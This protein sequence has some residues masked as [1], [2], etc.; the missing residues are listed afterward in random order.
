MAAFMPPPSG[1]KAGAIVW[2]YLRDSGGTSQELSVPQQQQE[3]ETFCAQYGFVRAR[4]FS[5]VARSGTSVVGRDA[6]LQMVES[7]MDPA[8]RPQAILV[9]NYSRIARDLTDA[10]Y[11]KGLIRRCGILIHSLTDPVTEGEYKPLVEMLID[12]SNQ[13]K[14]RQTSRDVKRALHSMVAQGFS[15]GGNPPRGYIEEK[16]QVGSKRDGTPRVVSRWVPDPELWE[17]GQQAW[18]MRAQ[19]RSYQE[20]QQATGG[21]IYGSKGSWNS[22]FANE[23]YLGIGKCGEERILDHHPA[24]V[25]RATWDRVQALRRGHPRGS[26]PTTT[27]FPRRVGAPSLLVGL[28]YCEHCG[29]ALSH[30]TYKPPTHSRWRC[31]ICGRKSRQGWKSCP[32]RMI[33]ARN[34]EIVVLHTVLDRILTAEAFNDLLSRMQEQFADNKVLEREIRNVRAG[35]ARVERSINN[36]LDV[37]ESGL[38]T[39][40]AR[41]R[42]REVERANLQATLQQL[43]NKRAAGA[44]K[45]SPEAVVLVLEKWRLQLLGELRSQDIHA[46]RGVLAQLITRID[47]DYDRI[48]IHY[49]YPL[50]G[51]AL[52]LEGEVIEQRFSDLPKDKIQSV[53]DVAPFLQQARK[54]RQFGPL[55]ADRDREIYRLFSEE[56]MTMAE[57]ASR[58]QLT[59]NRIWRICMAM[60]EQEG[61]A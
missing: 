28:A 24:M 25:D 43:E 15:C 23:T 44:L 6:F 9:W 49:R 58:Y 8:T 20:I 32:G 39:A 59:K 45:I 56:K 51:S 55:K 36:L 52:T 40:L 17:L 3:V 48:R 29:S 26:L 50:N 33:N 41:L 21:R 16:V 57:L 42:E 1:L 11:Y 10:S 27:I 2:D 47:A 5:D 46:I 12:F 34:A 60:K 38:N 18:K 22:F 30:Q 37:L 14:S 35:L 61:G 31:Y 54:K 19:G 4:S 13:E 53:F 7:I